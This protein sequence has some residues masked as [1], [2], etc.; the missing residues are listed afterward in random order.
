MIVAV[1]GQGNILAA[2]LLGEAALSSGL[3]VRMSEFHGMAQRGGVV[4]SMVLLGDGKSY[5]IADGNA[6]V[7]VGFEP[8]ET[9]R[10]ARKC[11]SRTLVI[12]NTA[13]VPPFTVALNQARYP[14]VPEAFSFFEARVGRL[15]AFD[16]TKLAV[17]AGSALTLNVVMLGALVG[18][19]TLELPDTAF[20]K[21]IREKTKAQFVDINLKAFRLGVAAAENA[22]PGREAILCERKNNCG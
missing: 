21:V 7:L 13:P 8:S 10:A 12:T 1:G 4:E 17:A 11:G 14:D 3:D 18:S 9:L 6:D 2:R 22:G 16:A 20:E 19:H 5:C 15:I